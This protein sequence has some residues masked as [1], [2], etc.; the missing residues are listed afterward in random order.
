MLTGPVC[1]QRSHEPVA[2]VERQDGGAGMIASY[3]VEGTQN[4]SRKGQKCALHRIAADSPGLG[5]FHKS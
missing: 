5:V 3:L 4:F 1:G 2:G